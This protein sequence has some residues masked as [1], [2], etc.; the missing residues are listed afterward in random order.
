MHSAHL[1]L[2]HTARLTSEGQS[3][4]SEVCRAAAEI[5][6]GDSGPQEAVSHGGKCT[7]IDGHEILVLSFIS[8][9]V[10]RQSTSPF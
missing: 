7:G 6:K 3:R 5:R 10:L 8:Y 1:A 4:Y 9:Y 2:V